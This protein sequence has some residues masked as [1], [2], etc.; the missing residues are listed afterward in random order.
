MDGLNLWESISSDEPSPRTKILHN[1]DDLYGN[2]ALTIGEWKL[3]NGTTYA[4]EYDGWFGPAGDRDPETYLYNALLQS[5]T[6]NILF[7]LGHLPT[8]LEVR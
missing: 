4:G 6:G 3:I 8:P 1:I 7:E 2:S 5:D